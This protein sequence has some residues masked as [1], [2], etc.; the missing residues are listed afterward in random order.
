[1]KNK[2][3][4]RLNYATQLVAAFFLGSVLSSCKDSQKPEDTKE[5]AT[6]QN[7]NKS[8]SIEEDSKYLVSAAEINLEEVQLGM[9]AQKNSSNKDVIALG[10]MMETEH[11]QAMQD[12]KSTAERKQISIPT[13]I[14]KD[15]EDA[16]NKLSNKTGNDF[17]KD[18]C[19]MMVDGHEKAIK[20]FEDASKD[21]KDPEIRNWAANMLPTLNNH[22]EHSRRCKEKCSS[23][24]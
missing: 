22:L 13:S 24:K 8:N 23:M 9:L 18:Y 15:G 5:V 10:K 14:T 3:T 7:E 4:I 21:A 12:L 6:E 17:D 19:D 16:Y 2:T 11:N 1:M 20:K